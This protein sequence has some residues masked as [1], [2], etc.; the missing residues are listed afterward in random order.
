[1]AA[2]PPED[3]LWEYHDSVP[4]VPD[5]NGVTVNLSGSPDQLADFRVAAQV[6]E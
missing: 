1:M 5:P 3:V 6:D 4:P 2:A